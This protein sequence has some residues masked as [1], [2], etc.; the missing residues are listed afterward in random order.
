MSATPTGP[1][2]STPTGASASNTPN[3]SAPSAFRRPP[4]PKANPLV[5]PKRAKGK[6]ALAS[7]PAPT[8]AKPPSAPANGAAAQQ[9]PAPS[10]NLY[11]N[12]MPPAGV[13]VK[14]TPLFT[15]KR[16][17]MEG[18]RH[19]I[20]K[21]Q[22]RKPIN[23]T[24]Q[25]EFTRPIRLHRR[26]AAL[27]KSGAGADSGGEGEENDEEV[28]E[29]LR[30]DALKEERRRNREEIQAQI[31]PKSKGRTF[32]DNKKKIQQVYER[33]DT[34]KSVKASRLRYEETLPWH[35]EDF[36]NKNTW[37]G[38]YEAALSDC[39]VMM[40]K[41]QIVNPQTGEVTDKYRMVPI[42]KWYKFSAKDKA[43]SMSVEEIEKQEKGGFALSRWALVP[44]GEP[45]KSNVPKWMREMETQKQL[46]QMAE[47]SAMRSKG[48]FTRSGRDDEEGPK[49]RSKDDDDWMKTEAAPDADIIDYDEKE[50]FA[51]DEEG[52]NGLFEGDDETTKDAEEKIKREQLSANFFANKEEKDVW[53]QE[54]EEALEAE[55][56][57]KLEKS[58]RKKIV[59]REKNYNYDLDD[60]DANPY[61]EDSESEDSEAERQKE[62]ER[63]REEEKAAAEKGKGKAT[64]TAEKTPS[65]TSTKG[66][67]TPSNRPKTNDPVKLSSSQAL[68][69]PGSPNLSEQSGNES[70][71]KKQKKFGGGGSDSDATDGG[72]PLASRV[73]ATGSS[74][75]PTPGGSRAGSPVVGAT[76][77]RAGSP[78][79]GAKPRTPANFG[80]PPSV[81]EIRA[82]IPPEGASM[83]H[84]I[85]KFKGRFK[86]GS[87]SQHQFIANVKAAG[88]YDKTTKMIFRKP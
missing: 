48:L 39:H 31:A 56:K 61:S 53:Q 43:V 30:I 52:V 42:E 33:N 69:R 5:Q 73:K 27:G 16:S 64:E 29:R 83:S 1:S 85:S 25:E 18:L 68:K 88:Q 19:H 14:A 74:Q 44:Q 65:G 67:N 12:F 28:K 3:G 9:K 41:E 22:S 72:K 66:S 86:Q 51:D 79:A 55:L 47:D 58:L 76:G 21:F 24:D 17:L 2:G 38:A 7:R 82:V 35:L 46:K 78:V 32:I 87:P 6:R 26:D 59:K 84:L 4:K 81:E 70:S 40:V 71:R 23:P 45:K 77:S 15:T 34:A 37:V 49:R 63:K 13:N 75:A 57:K 80:P 54:E 50:E 20:V 10:S 11:E 8:G 60:S 36:D 62:E